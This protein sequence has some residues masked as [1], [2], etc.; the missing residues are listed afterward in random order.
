M[1]D[2]A[3]K[4]HSD[5]FEIKQI[6][7]NVFSIDEYLNLSAESL[8]EINQALRMAVEEGILEYKSAILAGAL[9]FIEALKFDAKQFSGIDGHTVQATKLLYVILL[10]RLYC[11]GQM[12]QAKEKEQEELKKEYQETSIKNIMAEL[13]ML[14]KEDPSLTQKPEVKN[15]LLQFKIYQK[16]LEDMKKLQANIPKEKL[17]SF[18]NNLKNTLEG[19]TKKIEENYNRLLMEKAQPA[20][21]V[22]SPGDLRNHDMHPLSPLFL[23]QAELASGIRSRFVFAGD[24]RFQIRE[25]LESAENLLKQ[26]RQEIKTEEKRYREME[27]APEGYVLLAKSFASTIIRRIDKNISARI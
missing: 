21:A 22:H 13:Q 24:E 23:A 18:L 26:L 4:V 1:T 7:D 5:W 10:Q 12:P 11:T 15:I 25:V 3:R 27:P 2:L 9:S 6:F 16:E 8:A 14:V 17:P 20:E 19:I